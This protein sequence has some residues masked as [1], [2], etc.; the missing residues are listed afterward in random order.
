MSK[1]SEAVKRWRANTKQ[2]MINAMGGE[3]VCCEYHR[4]NDA[5]ELHHIDPTEKEFNFGK[6]IANPKSWFRIVNELRKCVLVCAICHRE[7]HAGIR[8]L[9]HD[10][11]RFDERYVDSKFDPGDAYDSC[12]IC[13]EPKPITTKYCSLACSGTKTGRSRGSIDWSHW[14][15]IEELKTKSQVALAEEI[16][17]SPAAIWKRIRKT[18]KGEII[19]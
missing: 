5:L 16:G 19:S 8:E 14:N 9:P 2:R 10:H 13:N 4:C 6:I 3:C 15:L 1:Q 7:I 12:P 11:P 17:V 18:K